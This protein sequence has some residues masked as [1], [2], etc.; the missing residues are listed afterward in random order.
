MNLLLINLGSEH[1]SLPF[2]FVPTVTLSE[3][4]W[5]RREG[6]DFAQGDESR[7]QSVILGFIYRASTAISG[8]RN[9]AMTFLTEDI[10][11]DCCEANILPFQILMPIF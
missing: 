11:C 6:R 3:T 9:L 1:R 2:D 4:K 7:D 10:V 8:A 5:S